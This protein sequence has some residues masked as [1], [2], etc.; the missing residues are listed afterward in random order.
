M[1]KEFGMLSENFVGRRKA[2]GLTQEQLAVHVGVCAKTVRRAEQG[3]RI[4]EP[5]RRALEA[6]LT[7]AEA[8]E[9]AK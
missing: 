5:I 2:V 7:A 9:P 1:D 4:I 6:A 8:Q 3:E